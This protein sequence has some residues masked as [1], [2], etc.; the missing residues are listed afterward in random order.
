M[1]Q[2]TRQRANQVFKMMLV[3]TVSAAAEANIGPLFA[4]VKCTSLEKSN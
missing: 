1:I 3:H 4:C 2:L